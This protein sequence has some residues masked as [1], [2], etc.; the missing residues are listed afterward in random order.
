MIHDKHWTFCLLLCV[1]DKKG[2]YYVLPLEYHN[3][4]NTLKLPKIKIA[5][6]PENI[7]FES[8]LR[9]KGNLW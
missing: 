8:S 5:D 7:V 9:P 3:Y 6:V 4:I 1:A 2:Q